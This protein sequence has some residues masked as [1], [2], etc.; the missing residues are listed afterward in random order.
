M[1]H[2]VSR[3]TSVR[4]SV[5]NESDVAMLFVRWCFVGMLACSFSLS[6]GVH[7]RALVE[8]VIVV[9]AV[10]TDNAFGP[11]AEGD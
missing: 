10:A 11:P 7:V 6:V 8:S 3:G 9:N 4:I 5:G 1:S 2:S